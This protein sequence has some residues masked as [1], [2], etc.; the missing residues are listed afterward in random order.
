VSRTG[1]CLGN[2]G[3]DP[4]TAFRIGPDGMA[5]PLPNVSPT[6]AQPFLPG[7]GGNAGASDVTALDPKYRPERTDNLT[8]SVQRQ[9]GRNFSMEVGYIGRIIRNEIPYRT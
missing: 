6:L 1:G 5:A 2:N 9:M 8:I 7:V 3:V 4:S